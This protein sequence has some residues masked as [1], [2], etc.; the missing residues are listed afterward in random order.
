MWVKQNINRFILNFRIYDD[1]KHY[2]SAYVG[3]CTHNSRLQGQGQAVVAG[4]AMQYY[5][6]CPRSHIAFKYLIM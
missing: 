2:Q 6:K 3:P 4:D 1:I 5:T